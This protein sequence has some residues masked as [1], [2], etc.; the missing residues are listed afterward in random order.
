MMG[1]GSPHGPPNVPPWIPQCVPM[2]PIMMTTWSPHGPPGEPLGAQARIKLPHIF[3]CNCAHF[4]PMVFLMMAPGPPMVSTRSPMSPMDPQCVPMD[5]L[6]MTTW[7]PHGPPGEPLGLQAR[8][9]LP[10][11]FSLQLCPCHP[12]G[13]PHDGDW[14]PP[15]PQMCLP[16][17]PHGS[18]NVSQWAPS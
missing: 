16:M 15:W 7:S 17:C 1:P 2:G 12:H 5:P 14:V 9:K 3:A 6:M 10:P 4:I 11:Q 8:I 18:P 13:P